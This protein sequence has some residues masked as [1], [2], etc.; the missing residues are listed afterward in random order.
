MDEIN[1]LLGELTSEVRGLRRDVSDDRKASADYRQG[2]REE[3]AKLVM[4][5]THIEADVSSLK[6]RVEGMEKVTVEV[7]TLRAKAQ[8]AGV[9]GYWLIRVGIAVVTVAGW[10]VGALAWLNPKPPP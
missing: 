1:R 10:I 7:T 5:Q 4:R 8:G 2:V 6:H 3:L 9:L